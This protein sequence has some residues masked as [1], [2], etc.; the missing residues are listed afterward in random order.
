M[1]NNPLFNP[2]LRKLLQLAE[3]CL[4]CRLTDKEWKHPGGIIVTGSQ[5]GRCSAKVA[6]PL[7]PQTASN[8]VNLAETF[9][10]DIDSIKIKKISPEAKLPSRATIG[11]AAYDLFPLEQRTILPHSR[12][13]IPTGLSCEMP[14]HLFGRITS[15]SGMSIKHQVDTISGTLDSDYRGPIHVILHNHSDKAYDL[16]PDR[17]MSQVLFLHLSEAPLIEVKELSTTDRGSGGFGSTNARSFNSEVIQLQ[18]VAGRP[19]GTTFMGAKPSKAT[20]RLNSPNGLS[21]QVI[22]DS[23]SNI[24]LVSTKLLAHIQ[25]PPK[26]KEGQHIRINQVTGRSS[27]TQYVPLKLFFETDNETVSLEIQAYIVK[28]MNAP[29]ILGNDYAD[30][31]SLSILREDGTTSLKLGNSGYTI[32]LDSSVDSAYL[33]ITALEAHAM[34]VRHRKQHRARTRQT[35]P[36]KVLAK[37]SVTIPPWTIRKLPI[38][39]LKPLKENA[40]L[41]P[42]ETPPRRLANATFLDSIL[43]PETLHVHVTNDTDFPIQFFESDPIGDVEP[44]EVL[45]QHPPEEDPVTQAFFNTVTRVLKP[46][47]SNLPDSEEQR[48]QDSQPDIGHGP[49]LAEVPTYEDTPSSELISSL[50][51]NPKLSQVQRSKLEEVI[52]KN[53]KAFSLD[54]RIGEYSDIK[55]SIKLKEGAEPVSM[56]PYHASPEKRKDIDKQID[57]WFSQGVIT[58]SESPW[59]APVIVVYRNGKARVCVDY[60]RVNAVTEAD[61]YPLPRQSDILRTLSGS[62]WLSTFDALSG[63]HQL[64]IVKEHRPIT[65]FRTHKYGLLEFTRL[66]F[67]LRNGP[68]VFQRVMN[69]VLSK[70]LWLFVLVYIDDIVVYSKSFDHHVQQLDQ[71]LGAI[72][73]ANITLSPSKCHIGYQS[74]ILLGQR[75]SRLGISTH[76]EK[77]DA[78]DAMKPPTKVKE[79]QMFL[80]FVNYFAIYIPFYTWIT[81]PLYRL[82]SKDAVWEWTP[83]HQEAY[84][85]CKL[86]LKSAPILAHHIEGKEYRLYTDASDFGIGAVLQQVQP[87]KIK[88]LKGTTLYNR[89]EKLHQNGDPPPQLVTIADKD[90][91]LPKT[92]VWDDTFE[93]TVVYIE[94]VIAY[95]SRLLKSAEKNYS[96]TEKEALALK[97][98][99]VKF[100]PFIE[101]EKVTAITDHSALQWSRTYHNINK[102]LATWGLTFSA[103]DPKL[104]IVHRAGRVHSNVDPLSRLER[105]IPFFDQPASND[106]DIDLSQEKDI[107]FYGRMKRKFDTR[108][109]SLFIALEEPTNTLLDALLPN[110]LSSHSLSYHTSTKVENHLHVDPKDIESILQEYSK[111]RHF[112][113]IA[114]SFPTEPPFIYKNYHRNVDGLIFFSDHSGRHRLCIPSSMKTDLMKEIHE[115][116]TGSA[117]AGFERTYGR[118]ANGF[119]W[120]KMVRDIRQFVSTCPICQKI[121]HARHLPYG[122]LQPIPIPTHPFEVV[123]M[124]FIGELP[125]SHGHDAIFVLICKLTKYAFFIPCNVNLSEKQAAQLFFNHIVTHV[126][127]PRQIISDRDTRWRNLFWKEVCESMGSRRALTTAYHPQADGQTEILNQTIEVAIRAFIN[128]SR[129]NWSTLLPYLAFAYNNTPHSATKF[130]PSFLLYGFHPCAPFNLLTNEPSIGRPNTYEFNAPDAQ[131]FSEEISSVRLIAKDALKLAQLRFETAYNKNHIFVPYS[132]GDQVLVNIHS[133]NLPESKGPGAKFTRRYDGPFEVTEQVSPVAYRI[134]LPHSYGIHPVLSIAHLEPYRSDPVEER[135]DLDRLREDPQEYEVEEIVEQRRERHRKRYRLMYR[136]RWKRYGVTDEWIP[137]SYLRNAKEVLDAWKLKQKELKSRK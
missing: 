80:G 114:N 60:R 26:P 13:L 5:K 85:L 45:D 74:L 115:S 121:K 89:L 137:E 98:A 118:I 128:S 24:S 46:P 52:R 77:I 11:S 37:E 111:D 31:Y 66:P 81:K 100:Q 63:F 105:R 87:I 44:L 40:I 106:P 51:F 70:F 95:W 91:V 30:Q 122:L 133:L 10:I 2:E 48:Y 113:E 29:L 65:A 130:T 43:T 86:A 54:G 96:P 3:R 94:R 42:S 15:R 27:T 99:L 132:P 131:L 20:V 50:D 83:I 136:C 9:Q 56:P 68:A 6:D 76:Q 72:A 61:E 124:D 59:G 135:K 73:K 49:N 23:G 38:R 57:K 119:F 39:I 34:A 67:G 129:D 69:K 78:V 53:H 17:A 58:H 97:D 134:R 88:D 36:N 120:P 125:K 127:L 71:T 62:Q 21:A 103:Y 90:E 14:S 107:D 92:E 75:V 8:I 1:P 110:N 126:G 84:E 104:K 41:T 32:P 19:P 102:R 117:H 33:E 35:R 4:S 25:P 93:E 47:G 64:E 112:K 16:H 79:L 28:D 18:P 108:A 82:L 109:S 12:L 123:T 55:Y 22:I 101:G 116:P 7:A